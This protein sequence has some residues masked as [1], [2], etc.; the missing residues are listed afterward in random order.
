MRTAADKKLDETATTPRSFNS[1]L[2]FHAFSKYLHMGTK[3]S[4]LKANY[5]NENKEYKILG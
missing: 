5:M 1:S 4:K 2:P 3:D